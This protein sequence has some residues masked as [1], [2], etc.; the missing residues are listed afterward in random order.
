MYNIYQAIIMNSTPVCAILS[1]IA[2]IV[3]ITICIWSFVFKAKYVKNPALR[4]G[5][6]ILC[7][8]VSIVCLYF[9]PTLV[10]V[11][12]EFLAYMMLMGYLSL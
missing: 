1:L 12:G 6:R 9:I 8:F 10:S 5:Y 2:F 3:C 7:L 11:I 4:S